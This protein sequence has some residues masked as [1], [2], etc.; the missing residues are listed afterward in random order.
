MKI[1][2]VI[3]PE[4]ATKADEL[5]AKIGGDYYDKEKAVILLL[6]ASYY[7]NKELSTKKEACELLRSC[8]NTSYSSTP[9]QND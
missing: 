3:K 8:M 4:W 1:I 9:K 7:F 5:I 2:P 6:A